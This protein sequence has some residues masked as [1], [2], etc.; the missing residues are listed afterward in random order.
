MPTKDVPPTRAWLMMGMTGSTPG[1][2]QVVYGRLV[3]AAHGRGALTAGQL[4]RLEEQVGRPGLADELG[5]GDRLTLLDVPVEEVR[6][7]TFPWYYFGAGMKLSAGGVRYRFSFVKPQNTQDEPGITA[8]PG[9]RATGR[10]WR[11][12]LRAAS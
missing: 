8:I 6:R 12:A 4:R 7:V 9:S 1:V 11:A 3:Y 2:L 5:D 10:T